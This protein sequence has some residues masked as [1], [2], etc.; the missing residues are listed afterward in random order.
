MSIKLLVL[1]PDGKQRQIR[2]GNF[3]DVKQ[4]VVDYTTI[5]AENAELKRAAEAYLRHIHM[6][7]DMLTPE[8][9]AKALIS[10]NSPKDPRS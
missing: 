9:R 4:L 3:D 1:T 2:I 8:Q 7:A 10:L 5:T 6:L